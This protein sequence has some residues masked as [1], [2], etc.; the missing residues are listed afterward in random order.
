MRRLISFQSR[1]QNGAIQSPCDL[2][3]GKDKT[4]EPLKQKIEEKAGCKT[5][6]FMPSTYSRDNSYTTIFRLKNDQ[7]I[8]LG[9]LHKPNIDLFYL[10][11][12]L[13]FPY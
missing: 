1:Q 10:L 9:H 8:V 12:E 13:S 4:P 3:R 6:M 7:S 5:H 2:Q 11:I